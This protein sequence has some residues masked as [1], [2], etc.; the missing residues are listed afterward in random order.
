[1]TQQLQDEAPGQSP[2]AASRRAVLTGAVAIAVLA[3][4]TRQDQT[5]ATGGAGTG[6]AV[7]PGADDG[8]SDD[9]AGGDGTPAP[10]A[11]SGAAGTGEPIASAANIP[12]GGGT[13]FDQRRVVVT[14]PK[15]GTFKAFSA[16]CTH[17]GCLVSEVKNGTINCLCHGSRFKVADGSVATG[18]AT[19]SL[20]SV[21]IA[22]SG[23]DIRLA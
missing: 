21:N 20:K 10:G 14:Q 15:Q 4:C 1:M 16:V 12:V 6:G 9:G 22:V 2:P 13:V 11:S 18:P 7:V 3:G 8:V 19:R 23:T 5:A 17:E